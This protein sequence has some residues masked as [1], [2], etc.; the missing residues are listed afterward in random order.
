MGITSG[1]EVILSSV[2]DVGLRARG[3]ISGKAFLAHGDGN[4]LLVIL[5]GHAFP[6]AK[7]LG[8]GIAD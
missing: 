5:L 1:G 6:R 7:R 2:A 3:I 8:F 4:R